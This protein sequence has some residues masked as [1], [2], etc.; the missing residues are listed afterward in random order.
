MGTAPNHRQ[1]AT[2]LA[3]YLD[4]PPI[5][6]YI[7]IKGPLQRRTLRNGFS[8]GHPSSDLKKL[9]ILRVIAPGWEQSQG[10]CRPYDPDKYGNA[11]GPAPTRLNNVPYRVPWNKSM[12]IRTGGQDKYSPGRLSRPLPL[13]LLI[14][15]PRCFGLRITRVKPRAPNGFDSGLPPFSSK[16]TRRRPM[17]ASRLPQTWWKGQGQGAGG[18]GWSKK[19]QGWAWTTVSW[20]K[21]RAPNGF[22]RRG[23]GAT[24]PLRVVAENVV[25]IDLGTTNSAVGA[26][27][28]DKPVIITNAEGQRMMPSV[29]NFKESRYKC[30]F[31]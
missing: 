31:T 10:G 13:L 11:L 7:Q 26:M 9:G 16:A 6:I 22:G 2:Y 1:N 25:G 5:Y 30:K 19:G 4:Q 29:D 18:E 28:G 24:G 27:E 14:V 8:L 12:G 17:R 3:P 20:I 23:C 21:P 15:D